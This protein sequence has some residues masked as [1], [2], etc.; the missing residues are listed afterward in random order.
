MFL[1][2]SNRE[3][4]I[5]LVRA[6][7]QLHSRLEACYKACCSLSRS[8][9]TAT[10]AFLGKTDAGSAPAEHGLGTGSMVG[11][12]EEA[13]ADVDEVGPPDIVPKDGGAAARTKVALNARTG[14]V[15]GEAA[16]QV[17][18]GKVEGARRLAAE[19]DVG[20]RYKGP[21]LDVEAGGQAT[22]ATGAGAGKIAGASGGLHQ[23]PFVIC[24]VRDDERVC[25][26]KRKEQVT[27]GRVRLAA[28][29]RAAVGMAHGEADGAAVTGGV[30]VD[31]ADVLVGIRL[32]GSHGV[33]VGGNR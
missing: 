17:R 24:R 12:L 11:R 31:R 1:S 9:S 29:G 27:E 20:A 22:R 14:A 26:S 30:D 23:P 5:L 21:G 4:L 13:N 18:I 2:A 7:S 33:D 19:D 8:T 10:D 15:G 6:A 25:G 28:L 32:A 16:V 3:E